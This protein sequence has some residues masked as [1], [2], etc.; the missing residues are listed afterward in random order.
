MSRTVGT[1]YRILSIE[2]SKLVYSN[3]VGGFL[4]HTDGSP[5]T[6]LFKGILDYSLESEK[7]RETWVGSDL[8]RKMYFSKNGQEY[9]TA[10]INVS[11]EYMLGDF[12]EVGGIYRAVEERVTDRFF[13]SAEVRTDDDGQ[14]RLIA[15]QLYRP[16]QYPPLPDEVLAPY[17]AYDAKENYYI[18]RKDRAGKR[19]PFAVRQDCRALRLALYRDGFI[20]DGVHYVRYKRSAGSSRSGQCLF[21]AAPLYRKMMKWSLCGLEPSKNRSVDL[22][23]FEAYVSL[24]LSS[25]VETV[26]IP[27]ESILFLK[28]AESIF[29]THAVS[30]EM[31]FGETLCS[32][33]KEVTIKNKIWD[34]EALLDVGVFAEK[35]GFGSRGM[36][37]LRN[38]FFKTCA[39]NTNLQRYFSDHGI[40]EVSR[41]CGYTQARSVEDIKMVVTESSL[42]YLKLANPRLSFE[43]KIALW[44][45]NVDDVFG[46]VKTDKPTGFFGGKIVQTSYQLINTLGLDRDETAAL[47]EESLEYYKNIRVSPMYMRNY[48]NYTLAQMN[49][50][51]DA[52]DDEESEDS[53]SL[54]NS[55]QHVIMDLLSLDDRIADTVIYKSFRSSVLRSFSKKI[56]SGKLLVQGTNATIFG[57]GY[58]LLAATVGKFKAGDPAMLLRGETQIS[59]KHFAHGAKL[60]GCRYPHVTMGNLLCA[61]NLHVEELD[62]YF[63]LTGEIVCVN[64]I[65]ANIQ[66]RLNGCDYDSDTMLLTDNAVMLRAASRNFGTF[67]VPVCS[68]DSTAKSY[69]RT[70]DGTSDLDHTIAQN[71]IGEIINQ[72]QIF[73]TL[74]WHSTVNT[75]EKQEEREALYRDICILAVLSGMEIDKAKRNYDVNTQ[76]VLQRLKSK[77]PMEKTPAFFNF[78]MEKKK[79]EEE[80]LSY[81]TTM[82][83]LFAHVKEFTKNMAH[84][85]DGGE[86]KSLVSFLS[87]LKEQQPSLFKS[88]SNDARDIQALKRY[89]QIRRNEI[90]EMRIGWRAKSEDEKYLLMQEIKAIYDECRSYTAHHLKSFYMLQSL[91]ADIDAG[92]A[93][94][95][96]SDK[97]YWWFLF[98]M[99][100]LEDGRQFYRLLDMERR[101]PIYHLVRDDAGDV[102]IYGLKHAKKLAKTGKIDPVLK[103]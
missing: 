16:L 9:T 68:I 38:R 5:D 51:L 90:G 20:C 22:A 41:L 8:S 63:N 100:C 75:P 49:S 102:S 85:T 55:R 19:I 44:L 77:Y 80:R 1:K 24:P 35:E 73:N 12:V 32:T 21:I 103:I 72:S 40:T 78:L 47:L 58:E 98:E 81:D 70:A 66:Q 33:E 48:I 25:I 28:D 79:K 69:A 34:G 13:N 36:M 67:S 10:V 59:C 52:E 91:L 11:F 86:K 6:K 26:R 82:D 29:R 27:K 71:K 4:T 99:L 95:D 64:A 62:R 61:T 60:L 50:V 46:I 23:S 97:K 37:L 87:P 76:S 92:M 31:A 54:F 93:A 74:Y 43:E 94:E 30:V 84:Q 56:R 14:M 3:G 53:V 89:L 65:E 96:S 18:P 39:F 101:E 17:F 2:A 15:I 83:Y 42:K 88:K 45:E 57:N 7:I